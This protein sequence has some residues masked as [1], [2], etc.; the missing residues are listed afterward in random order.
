MAEHESL[1]PEAF[2]NVIGQSAQ[3]KGDLV[4]EDGAMI[5]GS[6]DGTIDV[7]GLLVIGAHADIR[8]TIKAGNLQVYGKIDGKITCQGLLSLFHSALVKGD[9]NTAL[10][11]TEEGA[12]VQGKITMKNAEQLKELEPIEEVEE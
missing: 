6:V 9:I 4:L 7:K 2:S 1:T 8:A 3:V 10:L 12:M 5:D 11:T